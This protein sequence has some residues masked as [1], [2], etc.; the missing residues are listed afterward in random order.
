MC[1]EHGNWVISVGFETGEQRYNMA[2][3]G[4]VPSS[5]DGVPVQVDPKYGK[6][7]AE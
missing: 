4:F 3:Q 1:Q 6:I 7:V 2:A 5:L